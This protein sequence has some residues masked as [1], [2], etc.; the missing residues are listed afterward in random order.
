M[1]GRHHQSRSG[2]LY[3]RVFTRNELIAANISWPFTTNVSLVARAATLRMCHKH[4]ALKAK[5]LI[6]HAYQ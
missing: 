1:T 2:Y 3:R 6:Q 5:A 4:L